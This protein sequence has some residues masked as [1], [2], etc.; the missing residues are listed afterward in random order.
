MIEWTSFAVF[1]NAFNLF[2]HSVGFPDKDGKEKITWHVV[3]NLLGMLVEENLE[4]AQPLLQCPG[5]ILPLLVQIV[6]EPLSWHCLILQ[7]SIRS[8]TPAGKRKKRTG[9]VDQLQTP[10][11][12]SVKTS[13]QKLY[14]VIQMVA[15]WCRKQIDTSEDEKLDALSSCVQFKSS[16]GSS[17]RMLKLLEETVAAS[18]SLEVADRI[19]RALETWSAEDVLRKVISGQKKMLSEFHNICISK[20]KLLNSLQQLI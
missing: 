2:S 3:D 18:S 15:D 4:S 17:R 10:L 14:D 5:S 7:S 8:L 12:C 1:V 20:L 9:L 11:V 13:A 16:D 19:L 6:S